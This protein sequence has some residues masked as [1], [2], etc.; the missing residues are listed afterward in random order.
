VI[1][2]EM[3]SEIIGF[4]HEVRHEP[5][6]C[7]IAFRGTGRAFSGG[8]DVA[9]HL[10]E[11]VDA[12]IREFHRVFETLD[13]VG[14][15]TLALVEGACLGGACELVGYLDTVIATESASFGVPEIKLGVFPPVAAA[16]FPQRFGHQR[17]MQLLLTG[18]SIDAQAALGV[19]LVSRVV[20]PAEALEALEAAIAPLRQ[21]SASSLRAV[22]RASLDAR[23][24]TFR[25]LV[26]PSERVY[27]E[28][29]MA[30]SDAVEGLRAFLEKR[31][32]VWSHR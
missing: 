5:G 19:G 28:Q 29:L 11:T 14:A 13:E 23:R 25:E 24:A 3:I 20:P 9:S 2:F 17:A 12:M 22:K 8:V 26:A 15:P 21:R 27:L 31:D 18:N 4:L 30:T 10:P 16:L 1:D 7:A 6:L 32:P